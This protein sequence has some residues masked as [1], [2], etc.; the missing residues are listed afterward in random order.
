LSRTL[1]RLAAAAAA[2]AS[3]A[4]ISLAAAG[5]PAA[6][7]AA[8]ALTAAS[9]TPSSVWAG[10]VDTIR[11]PGGRNR[12]SS[13]AA[14]FKV[15]AITCAKS[16]VVGHPFPASYPGHKYWSA[17]AFW[18][19]LDGGNGDADSLEQAGITGY[20]TGP[21]VA[22]QYEAWYQMN[23]HH[24]VVVPL[25][26]AA[27]HPGTVRAGDT[28]QV[29]VR[30]TAGVT[31]G[32]P[33]WADPRYA[34]YIYAVTLKDTT[35]GLSYDSGSLKLRSFGTG[36]APGMTAEVITEA[37][38]GG[39]YSSGPKHPYTIGLARMGVVRYTDVYVS[40]LATGWIY[41]M[42]MHSTGTWTVAKY[43]IDTPRDLIGVTALGGI[44]PG[45]SSP[46]G[47]YWDAQ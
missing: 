20:C 7:P 25:R 11:H 28:I 24:N 38:S 18:A 45:S 10:Y 23:P 13:V 46:F 40:S 32:S 26:N 34:G 27:G 9:S 14:T 8:S 33:K 19:G 22:A 21:R 17:A 44:A 35:R 47:T 6:G 12:F 39:P 43:V 15:P 31:P 1:T 36:R 29:S 37:V 2:A 5:A 42:G 16:I 4:F 3:L 41:G 30:D